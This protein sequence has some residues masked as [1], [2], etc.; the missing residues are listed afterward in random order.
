MSAQYSLPFWGLL[1]G[2]L[3]PTWSEEARTR[4]EV[5][6]QQAFRAATQP[7][8]EVL[9]QVLPAVVKI[10]IDQPAIPRGARNQQ[11]RLVPDKKGRMRFRLEKPG[12]QQEFEFVL[13][14]GQDWQQ[15][16][17]QLLQENPNNAW[18]D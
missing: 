13:P 15:W 7:F 4:E 6:Q 10:N 14:P 9:A 5:E 16:L 2:L 8:P 17:Q 1:F 3:L 12:P 11:F 18:F